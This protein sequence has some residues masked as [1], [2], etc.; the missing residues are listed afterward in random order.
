MVKEIIIVGKGF[1]KLI[2]TLNIISMRVSVPTGKYLLD[3]FP[4]FWSFF[5]R[6]RQDFD[7]QKNGCLKTVYYQRFRYGTCG[8]FDIFAF[9]YPRVLFALTLCGDRTTKKPARLKGWLNGDADSSN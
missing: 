5:S 4:F 6:K 2:L 8:F 3:S 7:N 9:M 1:R